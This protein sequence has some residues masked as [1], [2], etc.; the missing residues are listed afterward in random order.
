MAPTLDWLQAAPQGAMA[1]LTAFIAALVAVFVTVLTQW[2]L[3][4]R[5]RTELLT[6]R[7]EELYLV[8]NE[9]SVHN[10]Q[11]YH[12]ASPFTSALPFS[13]A[14][15]SGSPLEKMGLDL[16]KKIVMYVRLYFP[17][18]SAAHL[19]VFSLNQAVNKLIYD[20]Q[21]DNPPLSEQKLSEASSAYGQA[22]LQMESEI[23]RN[24]MH[25]VGANLR[26][27]RYESRTSTSTAPA[28]RGSVIRGK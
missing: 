7:L 8:L 15:F 14:K 4:R 26:P 6:K 19:K 12:E 27:W 13:A 11:R 22:L 16:H 28:R 3:G 9:A 18:L 17:R 23:I 10:V 25:L 5:A 21:V 2:M 1:V 20:A 24:K